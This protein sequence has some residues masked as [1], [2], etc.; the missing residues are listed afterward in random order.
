MSAKF[1]QKMLSNN[2]LDICLQSTLPSYVRTCPSARSAKTGFPSTRRIS[3][4]PP[5]VVRGQRRSVESQMDKK[6]K[7]TLSTRGTPRTESERAKR[8]SRTFSRTGSREEF[9]LS[10]PLALARSFVILPCRFGSE[11]FCISD[12]E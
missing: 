11:I 3:F 7:K 10:P 9:S 6:R 4:S 5:S 12:V 1:E 2:P 8:R